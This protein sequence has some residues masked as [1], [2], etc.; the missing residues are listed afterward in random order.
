MPKYRITE[1]D[2]TG[3]VNLD[4][5]TNV[6]YIPGEL[7][8]DID[9]TSDEYKT[10]SKPILYSTI[11]S[12]N[13]N[14]E[15]TEGSNLKDGYKKS[16]SLSLARHLIRLGMQVL[17]QGVVKSAGVE[18]FAIDWNNLKD[19]NLYDIRFLTT[20]G[21][22]CSNLSEMILCAQNRGD[23]VALIDHEEG[24]PTNGFVVNE[25][26]KTGA[27]G[28]RAFY[29]SLLSAENLESKYAAGFTPW[30]Y[31]NYN[32]VV[33]E[34]WDFV[35]DE[36]TPIPA[37]FGYLFAY[38]RSIRNNPTWKAVAGTFRGNIPELLKP[39]YEY[40]TADGEILLGRSSSKA[41]T[42]DDIDNG[43]EDYDGIGINPILFIRGY[44]YL[45]WGNATL[46]VN[47]GKFK[48]SSS[49]SIRQLC[50]DIKK[51]AM[52]AAIRYTFEQNTNILWL[53]FKSM[54]TPLLDRAQSGEGIESYEMIPIA[55][56]N[57]Q[58]LKARIT[59]VPIFDVEDFDIELIL[60]DSLTINE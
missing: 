6:V 8:S 11:K 52:N 3:I 32:S 49:L 54:I 26:T 60:S 10:L 12:L 42:L 44:G 22:V 46:N 29:E 35:S 56:D 31:L 55:T 51:T 13:A 36:E 23:C 57:K 2:A 1:I 59:I 40:S 16:L 39:T 21:L 7:S 47:D 41:L 33:K 48:A 27:S 4:P 58:R 30:F 20:G 37:C 50:T 15:V 38:A 25:V 45:I 5:I 53:N 24:L 28:V 19:K 34:D 18:S 17:Y 43:D 9:V 14:V